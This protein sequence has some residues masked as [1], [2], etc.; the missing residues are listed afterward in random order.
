MELREE[1]PIGVVN[2]SEMGLAG[3]DIAEVPQDGPRRVGRGVFISRSWEESH[4]IRPVIPKGKEDRINKFIIR[5]TGLWKQTFRIRRESGIRERQMGRGTG[6]EREGTITESDSGEDEVWEQPRYDG[7]VGGHG[8]EGF[9]VE[10]E[11]RWISSSDLGCERLLEW[12]VLLLRTVEGE[13][14]ELGVTS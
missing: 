2:P 12:V 10:G 11:R 13:N 4:M 1:V 3:S 14:E 8:S 6:S 7:G 9:R 5:V